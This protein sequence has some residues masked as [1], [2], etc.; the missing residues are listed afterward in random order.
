MVMFNPK[1]II[2]ML[3]ERIPSKIVCWDFGESYDGS[4]DDGNQYD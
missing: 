4:D 1:K 3:K 2:I